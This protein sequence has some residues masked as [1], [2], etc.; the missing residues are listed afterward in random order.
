MLLQSYIVA[1]FCLLCLIMQGLVVVD[2]LN[3]STWRISV[4]RRLI[5]SCQARRFPQNASEYCLSSLIFLSFHVFLTL[6]LCF[7]F[8]KALQVRHRAQRSSLSMNITF[9]ICFVSGP[10]PDLAVSCI[11]DRSVER[12]VTILAHT[13]PLRDALSHYL[14][15]RLLTA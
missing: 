1:D 3:L 8:L 13:A 5:H 6:L 4:A 12:C 2:I 9:C 7:W 14:Y 10:L 15:R 11:D